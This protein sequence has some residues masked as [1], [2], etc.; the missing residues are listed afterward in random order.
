MNHDGN[1]SPPDRSSPRARRRVLAR[2]AL[3]VLSCLLGV[4]LVA[5]LI[6]KIEPFLRPHVPNFEETPP[7]VG[8]LAPDFTLMDIEGRP[9][10]LAENLGQ[11]PTV[12]EFGSFS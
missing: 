3:I 6:V 1:G 12:I 11:R 10:H 5:Q 8:A 7:T 4:F 2:G 9:Y